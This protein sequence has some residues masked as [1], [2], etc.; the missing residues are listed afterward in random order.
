MSI[1]IQPFSRTLI[2]LVPQEK[3][4][5]RF[6]C[7]FRTFRTFPFEI[8]FVF[9]RTTLEDEPGVSI[10]NNAISGIQFTNIFHVAVHLFINRSQM[11]SKGGKNKKVAHEPLAE[12]VCNINSIWFI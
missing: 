8:P 3:S 4:L 7:T 9:Q 12:Y 11:T 10:Q 2:E 5:R 1:S 6:Q